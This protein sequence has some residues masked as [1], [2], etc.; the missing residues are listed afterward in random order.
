MY[1][2]FRIA[3]VTV[4]RV[5]GLPQVLQDYASHAKPQEKEGQV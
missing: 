5:T 4:V 3:G 2:S 1:S